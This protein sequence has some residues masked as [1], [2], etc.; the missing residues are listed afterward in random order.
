MEEK[1]GRLERDNARLRRKIVQLQDRVDRDARTIAQLLPL[2]GLATAIESWIASRKWRDEDS[3]ALLRITQAAVKKSAK[4]AL[5]HGWPVFL[6][7]QKQ[8]D[9]DMRAIR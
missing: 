8:H 1:I 4:A 6:G 2:R 3:R 5:R 9:E 7:E